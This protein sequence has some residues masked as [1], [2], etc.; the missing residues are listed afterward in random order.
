MRLKAPQI[1][2]KSEDPFSNDA[3]ARKDQVVNLA[4][5]LSSSPEPLVMSINGPWGSGKTTFLKML[6][7][8]LRAS[9]FRTITFN[10]WESDYVEDPLP[11]LISEISGVFPS[12]QK[13]KQD[14][15]NAGK[16]LLVASVPLL[17]K[18]LTPGIVD[19]KQ[20]ISDAIAGAASD[21]VAAE[22]RRHTELRKAI[23]RFRANL[24]TAADHLKTNSKQRIAIFVD[25]L[26]RC[27]PI[28]AVRVLE[29]VK[30]IFSVADIHFILGVDLRQLGQSVR[31]VYGIDTDTERYLRRFIDVEYNLPAPDTN[32]YCDYFLDKLDL[33]AYF[34]ARE[35][36]FRRRGERSGFTSS[37]AYFSSIFGATL[38][39][40][41]K[42]LTRFV[43]VAWSTAEQFELFPPLL[44]FLLLLYSFDRSEYDSIVSGNVTLDDIVKYFEQRS[45]GREFL[46]STEDYTGAFFLAYFI[47]ARASIES[48][49]TGY[50][51][52]DAMIE[53]STSN[54]RK[55]LLE[56]VKSTA[57][58]I[59]SGA[60]FHEVF[61]FLDRKIRL[62]DNFNL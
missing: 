45:G 15:V 32:V 52:I 33:K 9:S 5:L 14:L 22:I 39:D 29:I 18:I 25:E 20:P 3:L 19:V 46:F 53:R 55:K 12:G 6:D 50:S 58:D 38:R 34:V 54:N 11:A 57:Q 28:Y 16:Q 4:N 24:A 10:A 41:E 61:Q 60:T 59:R 62:S 49:R 21:F 8:Q 37:L 17:V 2:V 1:E 51:E 26:D 31:H 27:K 48:G 7:A 56:D 40:I 43:L 13:I 30:H 36:N 35:Q 44:A 23:S 47:I 42:I